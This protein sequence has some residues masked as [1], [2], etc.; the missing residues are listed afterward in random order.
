MTQGYVSARK[1]SSNVIVTKGPDVCL[2]PRGG[3]M[4]PVPYSSV[5]KLDT[6]VRVSTT[7]RNNGDYDFQLNS[8]CG[9]SEGNDPGKGK[10]IIV[11]GYKGPAHV[12]VASNFVYSEGFA[13]CAHRDQAWINGADIGPTEPR[14]PLTTVNVR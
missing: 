12:M 2:T 13:T 9:V 3:S 7:V 4:V 6:S 8:R 14:K 1:N 5:A 10:G 11:Q